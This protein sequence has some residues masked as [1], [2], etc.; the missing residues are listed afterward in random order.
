MRETLVVYTV[1]L[2]GDFDL[3][4]VQAS[5]HV[6]YICFSDQG[7]LESNG[8]TIRPVC[9]F[10]PSDTFRSS[11][12]F[13]IR[14]HRWLADYSKSIY[15]DSSVHLQKDPLELWDYLIANDTVVFGG[16]YHSF[17]ATVADEFRAV[18]KAKLDYKCVLDEQM[19]AYCKHHET[20]LAE[21]PVWGGLLAR[22]HNTSPCINAM[23]VWFSHVLRF[24]RRDQ[25]SLPLALSYLSNEQRSVYAKNIYSSE[26]HKWPV[27]NKPKPS[28]YTVDDGIVG[29]IKR[30]LL[31]SRPH[32][33]IKR[34]LQRKENQASQIIDWLKLN[35]RRVFVKQKTE[36]RFGYDKALGLYFVDSADNA[37]RV[38]VSDRKR[39]E[40]YRG[41]IENRQQWILRDYRIPPDLINEGDVVVD[42]GANVGELGIWVTSRGGEYIAFEPDPTAFRALQKNITT[43]KLYDVALSDTNGTVEFHL[44][45]A[46]ADSSLFKPS[47]SQDA[48][49]VRTVTLD[50][51]LTESG[52]PPLIRLLKIEAEGFEAEVLTG[53]SEI[54]KVVEYVAVD[55]GPERGGENTV[56]G[57]FNNLAAAGFEVVDC[58]LLRETF[59]FRKKTD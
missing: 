54:L 9:P 44:S 26:Y 46:D 51:F 14:P 47:N 39:L 32:F 28:E 1:A 45:T 57:V 58:F 2:G 8:W 19:D 21:K 50:S 17:R 59:L 48:I 36:A 27:T 20:M 53:A 5:Y 49:S 11:R 18:A 15:I 10:I 25:L 38:Y 40:L 4:P 55:A 56:P 41:G 31:V 12:E 16:L 30:N 3:P 34:L 37:R 13:K 42:V 29:T 22:R 7:N 43:G 33:Y 6:H 35:V 24:S 52:P 23:E